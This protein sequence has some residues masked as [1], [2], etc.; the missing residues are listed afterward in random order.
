[1]QLSQATDSPSFL[2]CYNPKLLVLLLVPAVSH[3][4]M[5][6]ANHSLGVTGL[7]DELLMEESKL[8]VAMAA[9]TGRGQSDEEPE[10]QLSAEDQ[11]QLAEL[12]DEVDGCLAS[13]GNWEEESRLHREK[14]EKELEA[15]YGFSCKDELQSGQKAADS[16]DSEKD[17]DMSRYLGGA[18]RRQHRH[19]T[20]F[21]ARSPALDT[22][23]SVTVAGAKNGGREAAR[24][25][26]AERLEKLRAEVEG[27]RQREA[28]GLGPYDAMPSDDLDASLSGTMGFSGLCTEIDAMSLS[29]TNVEEHSTI[30]DARSG[31]DKMDNALIGARSRLDNDIL[32]ME[33]LLA[34]C[35]AMS[36]VNKESMETAAM[37]CLN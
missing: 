7:L 19:Q 33:K 25:A 9:M 22:Q 37:E 2:N 36:K 3:Q 30:D 5:A 4:P 32:E 12:H 13:L 10:Q 27:M 18:N 17:E 1:M 29:D 16:D 24:G 26:D 14:L 35:S 15:Q 31:L 34:E 28:A 20:P 11:Q 21:E 23:A 8:E 6:P